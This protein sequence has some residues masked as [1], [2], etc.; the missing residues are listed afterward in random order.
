MNRLA[1]IVFV[2]VAASACGKSSSNNAD[3]PPDQCVQGAAC[4]NPCDVGN[5]KGVGRYCTAGGGECG[6]NAAPIIFCTVDYEPTAD[7]QYCTGPC[8]KDSDCGM[9]AY[10]SG[11]GM[12]SKGC[13][14]A[15]CGGM[16]SVD[17]GV[18]AL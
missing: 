1:A 3:A 13:E 5:D 6:N 4:N 16:P 12:G 11:S 2:V 17:A 14:P 9:N 7:V 18:D 15:A 10:C 8:S